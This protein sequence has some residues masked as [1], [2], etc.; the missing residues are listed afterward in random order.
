[1]E[2]GRTKMKVTMIEIEC[3]A[4]ELAANRTFADTLLDT[5]T[6]ISNSIAPSNCDASE[7]ES[8]DEYGND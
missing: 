4:D 2:K 5:L 6:R 7:D 3:N 1:M 8:E